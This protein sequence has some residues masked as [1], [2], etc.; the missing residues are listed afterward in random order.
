MKK[1]PQVCT[2]LVEAITHVTWSLPV[3]PS[4]T[5]TTFS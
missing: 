5:G 4:G 2:T 3:P 1:C